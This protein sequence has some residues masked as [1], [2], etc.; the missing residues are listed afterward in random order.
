M[1][2]EFPK[3]NHDLERRVAN[4]KKLFRFDDDYLARLRNNDDETARHFQKHFRKAVA[5]ML[6]G[7]FYRQREEDLAEDVMAAV[8]ERVMAGEPREGAALP[9]Y[10]RGVCLNFIRKEIDRIQSR[11]E[12]ADLDLDK[13]SGH[14]RTPE[15]SARSKEMA[16]AVWEVLAKLRLRY[17]DILVDVFYYELDRDEVRQKYGKTPEQMRLILFHARHSFQKEWR[18]NNETDNER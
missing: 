16:K 8:I 3:P 13:M 5:N 2:I 14:G 9:A 12:R 10:V 17:R 6:F 11:P 18:K 7:K 4:K 1:L 15:E